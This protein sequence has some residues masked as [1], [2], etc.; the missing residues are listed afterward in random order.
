MSNSISSDTIDAVLKS[1]LKYKDHSSLKAL[2]KISKPNGLFKFS[3]VEKR[4]ILN[5]IVNLDTSKS[6]QDTDV[7]TKII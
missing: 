4:K 2:E 6:C 7:P 1:V 5:E 3:N